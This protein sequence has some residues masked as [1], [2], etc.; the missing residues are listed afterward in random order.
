MNE[1][2]Q[3][4]PFTIEQAGNFLKEL[5][6]K[7][8]TKIKRTIFNEA[9]ISTALPKDRR[10]FLTYAVS[11]LET[12]SREN[13][14][15]FCK[16]TGKSPNLYS[17]TELADMFKKLLTLRTNGYSLRQI[18]YILKTPPDVLGKVEQIALMAVSEAIEKAKLGVPLLG[19]L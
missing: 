4:N 6:D 7:L 2:I 13:M 14:Q 3:R 19:G 11:L 1:T 5:K 15:L 12:V 9:K 8:V 16:V 17:G 10:K 18:A